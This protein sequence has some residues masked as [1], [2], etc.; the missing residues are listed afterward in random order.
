MT[1]DGER[2]TRRLLLTT[3]L[4]SCVLWSS[5]NAQCEGDLSWDFADDVEEPFSIGRFFS[6]AVTP[7]VVHDTQLLRHYVRDPRFAELMKRCGDIRAT[8]AIYLR[9]LK[10]ADYNIMRGLLLSMM[11]VLEHQNIEFRMPILKALSV[12]LSFEEDSLFQQRVRNL[13]RQLYDDTPAIA[14]GDRDKL[15]H[16]FASAYIAYASETPE[17]ASGAGAAVEWGEAQFV[18]GGAD[19]PRDERAN[20]QGELFGRDLI[21][22]KNLLPSDYLLLPIEIEQ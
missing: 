6:D 9:A 5:A 21:A 19:D 22:V 16:F 1:P 7:Q 8:D 11:A 20:K 3:I 17:L 15:Q 4:L 18:V 12:P 14:M 10:I 13:P 2:R